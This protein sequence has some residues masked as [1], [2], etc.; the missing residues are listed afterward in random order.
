M[1]WS[2][3]A[4]V[5]LLPALAFGLPLGLGDV[6]PGGV[7]PLDSRREVARLRAHFD[8][9]DLELRDANTLQLTPA[10]RT[11]R[12]TMVGW[13]RD[14][15][16]AGRFPRND[17]FPN[18]TVPFFRDSEGVLCA[19][20][21]LIER[22]GQ[23]DLVDRVASTR[24]NAFIP[25]LAD[26]PDLRAWLDSAGL[27]VAEAAR[28]QPGYGGGIVAD[29]GVSSSYAVTSILVSGASLTT[30]GLNLFAP[31]R[32]TGWAG[33]IAGSAAIIAGA[34]NFDGNDATDNV[35]AANVIAGTG[36]VA[37]GAYSL[38]GSR[39]ARTSVNPVVSP[40]GGLG[41]AVHTSF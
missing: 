29:E 41:L 31:N 8:S 21:Y 9:V 1:E 25:E 13:L 4:L 38:I 32:S 33:I 18:Q 36:A 11:A 24:N 22:S 27:S 14:Y 30:A 15:R 17:R 20:A 3:L 34:V 35:A 28:I 23:G 39:S 5:G 26:D 6:P 12:A 19:M 2:R 10:Q 7:T 40:T 37:L 16:E